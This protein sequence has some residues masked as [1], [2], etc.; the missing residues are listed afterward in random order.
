[1][2]EKISSKGYYWGYKT[3]VTITHSG[4]KLT[5]STADNTDIDYE[6][7]STD[8]GSPASNT[9]TFY[10]IA[11]SHQSKIHK[12]DHIVIKSGPS[13]LYGV[14]SEGN[15]TN[16]TPETL[17]SAD[18]SFQVT[19][20]EGIDYSKDKRL[21][22]KFNGSKMVKKT[23][24][25]GKTKVTYTKRQVKKV[26]IAF[27]KGVKAKQIIDRIKRDAKIEISVC[28]LKKNKV[29][30]KG[31][32]L[33]SKPLAAI[34]A[35]AKDCGSKVYYRQG[36]LVIDDNAKPNPYNEHLY[37]DMKNGLTAEPTADESDGGSKTYTLACFDDPRLS[38]GSAVYVK[39]TNISGLKRVKS[40]NH[41]HDKSTYEMEVVV[42][43]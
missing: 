1:M 15:I 39:A 31:Y 10:N 26:N 40:V 19:F 8:G 35:I 30:K 21:Y 18:K 37:L 27:K 6:V 43:A 17:D 41:K 20:T 36:K 24:T 38:A 32:T 7:N 3:V 2:K 13:D 33:S 14:L 29:Y 25:A 42:Y 22:S 28:R 12:G 16:I 34:K 5:L 9:V 11:K 23:V 4:N